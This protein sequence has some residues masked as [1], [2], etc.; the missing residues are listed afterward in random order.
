MSGN[1]GARETV[2]ASADLNPTASHFSRCLSESRRDNRAAALAQPD[3][4]ETGTFAPAAQDHFIAV[5]KEGALLAT[6]KRDRL[7]P[8]FSQLQQTARAF[9][10]RT[11]NGAAG[12]QIAGAQI[13]AVAGM[14][15]D[16]LCRSPV[17]VAEAADREARRL[18]HLPRAQQ[19]LQR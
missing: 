18:A 5:F 13:A 9:A 4:A 12:Q 6:P 19:D 1:S 10:F 15:R 2:I 3:A 17:H 7:L 14:V 11:G 8:A 16:H